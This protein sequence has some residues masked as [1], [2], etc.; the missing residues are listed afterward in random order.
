VPLAGGIRPKA[1]RARM[2][3]RLWAPWRMEYML[4]PKAGPCVLCRLASAPREQYREL[5]VLIVQTDAFVCLNRYPFVTSHLLVVSRRHVADI[6]DLSLAEYGALTALVRES[7]VRLRE[8]TKAE[9]LNVGFNLGK[10]AGAGIADHLHAH[11]VPR[12]TGDSNFMPVVADV[13]VMPEYLDASWARLQPFF[14]DLPGEHPELR[15]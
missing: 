13:R 5:L 15:S 14:A 1:A 9:G 3:E 6:A 2:S 8:A 10:S 7:I 4:G 12:W 11:V